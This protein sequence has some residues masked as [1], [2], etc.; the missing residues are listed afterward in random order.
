MMAMTGRG[1]FLPPS[2]DPSSGWDISMRQVVG[3]D[4]R[5]FEYGRFGLL[6]DNS[7]LRSRVEGSA[8]GAPGS[9]WSSGGSGGQPTISWGGGGTPSDP[10][11]YNYGTLK[12]VAN[13]TATAVRG[14]VG[15]TRTL[16]RANAQNKARQWQQLQTNYRNAWDPNMDYSGSYQ[17]AANAQLGTGGNSPA[18]TVNG[19]TT[20]V[21]AGQ[22]SSIKSPKN[23]VE[24]AN[25]GIQEWQ[26]Q[27]SLEKEKT[28]E[29]ANRGIQEWQRGRRTSTFPKP[30]SPVEAANKGIGD[31]LRGQKAE[32]QK[33]RLG[34]SALYKVNKSLRESFPDFYNPT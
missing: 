17:A 1:S 15:I 31:M 16:R 26:R 29:E 6:N 24:A 34:S 13:T 9:T 12:N 23:P 18:M 14:A 2:F 27:R 3:G 30:G 7:V 20:G 25:K 21:T 22:V 33:S 32:S 19:P 28:I 11:G 4:P 8:L 5:F 10:G